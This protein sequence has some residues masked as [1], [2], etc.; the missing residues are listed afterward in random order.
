MLKREIAVIKANGEVTS[1]IEAVPE[2]K[3]NEVLIKVHASLISPGTEMNL[4]R[5]RRTTPDPEAQDLTFGYANAGEI[6][7]VKGQVKG[8][9][10]GMRVAAMGGGGAKHASYACVPV[11]L[12]MPIPDNVSYEEATFACLGATAMHGIHRADARFSEFGA[13]LG[14]GI[15]G[16]LSCQIA[17]VAGCRMIGWE[18]LE[19]R[20]AMASACG[21]RHTV[22]FRTADPVEASKALAAPYGLDFAVL[23][24]GGNATDPL[25]KVMSCMKVSADGHAMGNIVLIGGCKVEVGG[26]AYSGNLNIKASSRTGAGYHDPAWEYGRDYPG[27]FVQFTTTRNLDEIIRLIAERRLLVQPMITHRMPLKEVGTAADL[28]IEHPDQAMGIILQMQH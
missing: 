5:L 24:F 27:A 10:P 12:V 4:P 13:I 14:L 19:N 8:L 28:L 20:L 11:N 15:V 22:N 21:I 23:A 2:L 25:Q 6:I 7:E 18:G 17:Q 1:R 9:Q 3:D 26:G 16:N